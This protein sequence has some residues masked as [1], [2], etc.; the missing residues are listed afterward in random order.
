MYLDDNLGE[1]FYVN[2]MCI[3]THVTYM[4]SITTNVVEN[5]TQFVIRV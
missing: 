2:R 3:E 1:K 4:I 5:D